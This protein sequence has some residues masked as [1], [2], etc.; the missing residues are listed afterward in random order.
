MTE[1][2]KMTETE[3][4]EHTKAIEFVCWFTGVGPGF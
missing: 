3:T 2:N 4:L 1:M